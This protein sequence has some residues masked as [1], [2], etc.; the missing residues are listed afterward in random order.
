MT[1]FPPVILDLFSHS[2]NFSRPYKEAGCEVI[3]IDIRLGHEDIRLLPYIEGKYIDGIIACPPCQKMSKARNKPTDSELIE[4]LSCFDAVARLVV[5]YKPSFWV[6]ENP[7]HSRI[8]KFYGPPR[9]RIVM[10]R[11]GFP[12][13]KETGLWGNFNI[14][15][16]PEVIEAHPSALTKSRSCR[17]SKEFE[18]MNANQRAETPVGLGQAFFKANQ[19]I[20]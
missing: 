5:L 1:L 8:R 14:V 10:S 9:Q 19:I 17:R 18:N 2:G 4:S 3:Q 11:F 13:S 7:F 20:H 6:F 15:K 16:Y 12:S